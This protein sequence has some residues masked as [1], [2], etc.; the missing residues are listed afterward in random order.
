ML[1]GKTSLGSYTGVICRLKRSGVSK[2]KTLFL[3]NTK[4][5]CIH[6]DY[7]A[8]FPFS[9]FFIATIIQITMCR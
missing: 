4:S 5:T 1:Q 8:F 2:R 9:D 3:V 7:S 6:S